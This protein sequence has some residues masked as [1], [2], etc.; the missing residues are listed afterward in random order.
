MGLGITIFL[1]SC[2]LI[3]FAANSILCRLALGAQQID[4]NAFTLIRLLSGAI[5]LL[6]LLALNRRSSA[7]TNAKPHTPEEQKGSWLS[8]YLLFQYAICFSFA[9]TLLSA[10]SGAIILFG[11]VQLTMIMISMYKGNRLHIFEWLGI[12]IAFGGFVY[13]LFPGISA[14]SPLGFY[15]M[16]LAGIAW[17][18]YT[19][20]GRHSQ[21]PLSD[22]TWNFV[23]SLPFILVLLL[24]FWSKLHFNRQGVLLAI[25]SGSIASGIGY[26]IWYKVLPSLRATQAAV[27]QLMV[28]ILTSIAGI[29]WVSEPITLRFAIAAVM[30]LGG[31]LLVIIKSYYV[32]AAPL[33]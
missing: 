11:T 10:A 28:P 14:P 16:L 9:Y 25:A 1:T 24:F 18:G 23:R 26:A 19:L 13:L 8:A 4:A 27:V 6:F 7:T 33:A 32:K 2:A 20:R 22:T 17:G 21:N 30:I 15:L 31:I 12:I 29:V 5:T 3:C